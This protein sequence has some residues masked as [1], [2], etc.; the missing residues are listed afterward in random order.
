[1]RR[2]SDALERTLHAFLGHSH[3]PPAV[4][5]HRDEIEKHGENYEPEDNHFFFLFDALA[6]LDLVEVVGLDPLL[7]ELGEQELLLFAMT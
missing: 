4:N 1:V 3:R 6:A 7:T 5:H 2:G